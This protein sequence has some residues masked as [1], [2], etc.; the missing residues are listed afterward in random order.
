ML[1]DRPETDIQMAPA[2]QTPAGDPAPAQNTP[3]AR[4]KRLDS[5]WA[6]A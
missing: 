1:G 5:A 3:A 6:D 2:A 4:R